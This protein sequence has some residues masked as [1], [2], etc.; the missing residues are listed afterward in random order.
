MPRSY[1]RMLLVLSMLAVL[2]FSTLCRAASLLLDEE[3][4]DRFVLE[5]MQSHGIPGLA[6][7]ITQGSD[8]R[9]IK[10]YGSAG[11]GEPVTPKRSFSSRR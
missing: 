5:Q 7:A 11:D 1:F 8:V 10:G 3:A 9:Y 2:A 4:I 6:L